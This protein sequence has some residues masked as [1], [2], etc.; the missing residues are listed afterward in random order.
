M[1]MI[2]WEMVNRLMR[3]KYFR[4]FQE[5]PELQYDYM[6]IAAAARKEVRPT[7]PVRFSTPCSPPAATRRGVN[8]LVSLGGLSD[9]DSQN[10]HP[11]LQ[12][13]SGAATDCRG[14]EE[15]PPP[16]DLSRPRAPQ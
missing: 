7:I 13:R 5:Y 11:L 4:P 2:L 8:R 6:I 9:R 12:R 10:H 14:R 15:F 3:G 1:G 16:A